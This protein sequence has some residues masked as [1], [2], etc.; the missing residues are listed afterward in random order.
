MM[1]EFFL[2]KGFIEVPTQSRT[3]ILAACENPHSV[4]TF[5][6]DG[7]VWP[8]KQTGQMDLEEELLKNP[9][10]P[11]C[12]CL[13]TSYRDEKNPIDGR[14]KKIFPIF[15]F[16][17]KGGIE[18]LKK[19]ERELLMW[20]GF[21]LPVE[22]KY[23]DVCSEYGGVSILE[24][25]HE[26]RMWKEKGSV[27]SLQDFGIRTSKG[28]GSPFWNMLHKGNGIFNKIDI[29]LYGQ[30]TI[31]S[32]E[33]SCDPNEMRKMFYS[34][35]DGEYAIKLFQLF[36]RER[37]EKE[38]EYFLSFEF[39]QRSGGGIGLTRL[40]RAWELL[41]EEKVNRPSLRI[42]PVETLA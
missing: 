40:A 10:W 37:V 34:I 23:D 38:L 18:E 26:S 36:G 41:Q 17:L 11:G 16:E 22:V 4:M 1:R 14:H 5:Q 35:M 21:G 2:Q 25:E 6:L 9:D 24:D 15:E 33:R 32:A 29:I 31:G 7:L 42:R 3:S 28:F 39:F 19:L 27:I 12:F 20:L 8:L 30:E 13:T